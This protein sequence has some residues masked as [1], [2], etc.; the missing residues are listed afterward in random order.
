LG[1]EEIERNFEA[2][3]PANLLGGL[4]SKDELIVD[5]RE[6]ISSLPAYLSEKLGIEFYWGSCVTYISDQTVYIGNEE[7]YEADIIFVCS[8]ADFETL[9]PETFSTLPLI[10][11]KL[12][13][14]RLAAQPAGWRIGPALAGG[15]SLIHYKSFKRRHPWR[16][17]SNVTWR[18]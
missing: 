8:G 2:V 14:M 11:C 9:F 18:I 16:S 10:K 6:S 12:Q 3:N 4:H 17:F 15:L 1:K 13:M 7:E 5:P